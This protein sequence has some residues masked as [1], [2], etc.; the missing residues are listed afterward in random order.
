M[1]PKD[2]GISRQLLREMLRIRLFEE[3]VEDRFLEGEIPGFVHLSHGHEGTH[4]GLSLNIEDDDWL[5]PGYSRLH[6]LYIA[7]G[8]PFKEIAAELYGKRN[9]PNKGKGGSMHLAD[10]SR[11]EMG[12]AGTIGSDQNPAVGI[13]LAQQYLETGNIVV[14]AIGDGGTNRGTF[15]AALNFASLWNLPIVFII[16]NNRFALSYRTSENVAAENLADYADPFQIPKAVIDGTDPETVHET[17]NEAFERARRG[18]GP[19]VVESKVYRLTGH[20]LGDK[21]EY[22]DEKEFER[23]REEHDP[24]KNYQERLL[25]EDV[26]DETTLDGMKEEIKSDVAEAIEY[27]RESEYPDP[28]EAYEGVYNT[29]LYGGED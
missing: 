16:D 22:R 20:F 3:E 1:D 15:H 23:L 8:V 26:I 28:E 7:N 5:V 13:A 11:N 6:G 29:P 2:T 9:G 17:L 18:D 4:A 27:A 19:T 25:E 24:V 21:Q 10:A 14:D 12:T